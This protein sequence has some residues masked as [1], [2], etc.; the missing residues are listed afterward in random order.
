MKQKHILLIYKLLINI[1][2]AQLSHQYTNHYILMLNKNYET[3]QEVGQRQALRIR[4]TKKVKKKKIGV[5]AIS[6]REGRDWLIKGIQNF[7]SCER[8][9]SDRTAITRIWN[10]HLLTLGWIISVW[11]TIHA[12]FFTQLTCHLC[13][14]LALFFFFLYFFLMLSFFFKDSLNVDFFVIVSRLKNCQT[15]RRVFF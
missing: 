9:G 6:M 3:W 10:R 7:F 8:E 4:L 2:P 13:L 14:L 5:V 12:L 15:N 11:L 1:N